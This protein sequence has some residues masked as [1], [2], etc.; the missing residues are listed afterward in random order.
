MTKDNQSASVQLAEAVPV[1]DPH[2]LKHGGLPDVGQEAVQLGHQ[3][4]V[5]QHG[6]ADVAPV[7]TVHAVGPDNLKTDFSSGWIVFIILFILLLRDFLIE[8][9]S[10]GAILEIKVIDLSF[11]EIACFGAEVQEE[12]IDPSGEVVEHS[13][14]VVE[15][16]I[17]AAFMRDERRPS[18]TRSAMLRS[19]RLSSVSSLSLASPLSSSATPSTSPWSSSATPSTSSW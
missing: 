13:L 15:I 1:T 8:K 6:L 10:L 12:L 16:E 18:R 5:S 14:D 9:T 19:S 17:G 4:L 7:Q 11:N 2:L 3:H